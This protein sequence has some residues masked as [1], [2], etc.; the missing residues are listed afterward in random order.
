MNE[1]AKKWIQALRSGEYDQT[2]GHLHVTGMGYCCLGVACDLAAMDGLDIKVEEDS[3]Y[4]SHDDERRVVKYDGASDLLPASVMQ[5]L[6]IRSPEGGFSTVTRET[7]L[8]ELNDEGY[9][10]VE[11]AEHIESYREQIFK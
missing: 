6:G 9:D 8:A 4:L 5:W 7:S 2:D 1:N 3:G 11:I 10:F